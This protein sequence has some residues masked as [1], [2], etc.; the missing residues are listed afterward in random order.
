M[1][2]VEFSNE[3]WRDLQTQLGE[4]V[5]PESSG[6]PFNWTDLSTL[7]D[8]IPPETAL[9]LDRPD[10]GA[11][12]ELNAALGGRGRLVAVLTDRLLAP[13]RQVLNPTRGPWPP[14]ED[15][16]RVIQKALE[17]GFSWQSGIPDPEDQNPTSAPGRLMWS[18]SFT[19]DHEESST[20]LDYQATLRQLLAL[21]RKHGL[22]LSDTSEDASMTWRCAFSLLP[23][24]DHWLAEEEQQ[25]L[26]ARIEGVKSE[27]A[28]KPR[29]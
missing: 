7:L 6:H 11:S 1:T 13:A 16:L 14:C 21:F 5:T 10:T 2:N 22:D 15:G 8:A 9:R 28:R 25:L 20:Y 17:K 24:M 23:G 29:F 26:N 19:E 3:D 4:L 18:A 27:T 12:W